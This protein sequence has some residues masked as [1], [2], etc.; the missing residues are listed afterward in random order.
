MKTRQACSTAIP[1]LLATLHSP[2]LLA[3]RSGNNSETV[4]INAASCMAIPD[5]AA[6][7]SCFET[8]ARAAGID[9]PTETGAVPR[10]APLPVL[11][12]AP[13]A[14]AAR[15]AI[16]EPPA[17]VEP[18]APAVAPVAPAPPVPSSAPIAE[19]STIPATEQDFGLPK[20]AVP[21]TERAEMQDS[22]SALMELAPNQFLITL[23]NGQVWRQVRPERY[24]L[25]VGNDVR[26][27]PSRWGRDY[28][29][30]VQDRRGFIQVERVR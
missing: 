5:A 27:Y 19:A 9:A 24:L 22:I 14:P 30:S 23:A 16:A 17:A 20:P 13:A 10:S 28:R 1:L 15:T 11:P 6:R 18:A 7:L 12:V 21:A 4:E 3:Q 29:L 8:Q 26:V 25:G 2:A